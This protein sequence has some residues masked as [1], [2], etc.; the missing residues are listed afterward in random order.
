MNNQAEQRALTLTNAK[1]AESGVQPLTVRADLAAFARAWALHMRRH[2]FAHSTGADTGHLVRGN[3]WGV[4]ENIV[5]WSD[6]SLSATAAAD[7]LMDMWFHSPG[8][9]HNMTRADYSEVGIGFYHDSSGW[10]GV[11]EF[12]STR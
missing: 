12:G 7:K 11:Q 8:H 4:G 3:R 2:G 1:R 9:L 6:G 5:W 10:W